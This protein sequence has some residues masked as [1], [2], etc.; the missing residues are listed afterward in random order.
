MPQQHLIVTATTVI[1]MDDTTP[2]AEAVAITGDRIVAVGSLANCQAALP[3]AD[4]VDTGAA[5]LLPGFVE[6]RGHPVMSGIAT[7]PPARSIAPWVAA[8]WAE[9]EA[10]FADAIAHSDAATPLWFAGFDALLL[11]HP[12]PKAD[13]LDRIFGEHVAVFTDNSGHGVYFNTALI[14]RYG[15]D[16][17]SAGVGART[18]TARRRWACISRW[19]R[20]STTTGAICSTGGCSTTNTARSGRRSPTPS[21]PAP[22]YRCTTTGRCRRRTR[23]TTSE[24]RCRAGPARARYTAPSRRSRWTRRCAR[25]R[26]AAAAMHREHLVGSIAVGKLADFVELTADPYAV[27]P[28]TLAEAVRV[29]WLGGRRI[30]LDAFVGAV[31]GADNAEH[32]HPP[33]RTHTPGC[34]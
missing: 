11:A 25:R 9:P 2:R 18:S 10:M 33:A 7:Q 20:S 1:T 6:P 15:W 23:S 4:I 32:A 26:N 16:V 22:V 13:E 8:T 34:C 14:R 29:A 30:D 19:P 31:G 12:A 21:T 5:A 3:G 24:P 17:M 27:D 28:V